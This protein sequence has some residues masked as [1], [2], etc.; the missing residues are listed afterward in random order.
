MAEYEN[1]IATLRAELQTARTENIALD[2]RYEQEQQ[3]MLS[4]WHNLGSRIVNQHVSQA[5]A[6]AKRSQ[7]KPMP[8]SWL[9]RQRRLQEDATF[10]SANASHVR[11][12]T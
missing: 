3:L 10:V 1:E 6:A 11:K 9:G 2:K 4:A 5:A 7:P 8:V 12:P